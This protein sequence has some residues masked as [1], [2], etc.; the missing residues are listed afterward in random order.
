MNSPFDTTRSYAKEQTKSMRHR[1]IL[2]NNEMETERAPMLLDSSRIRSSCLDLLE[3]PSHQFFAYDCL[4]N[5]CALFVILLSSRAHT[6]ID[7][8]FADMVN[9][10]T[11]VS[12]LDAVPLEILARILR[13]ACGDEADL[14]ECYD[15]ERSMPWVIS[16][17]CHEWRIL[18]HATHDLWNRI[19]LTEPLE[20]TL[21]A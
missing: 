7:A 18:S 3:P 1:L 15:T 5:L 2:P 4:S 13:F 16:Q 12:A 17:V 20:S 6:F 14:Y 19:V 9:M 10:N 11:S 21:V 8:T